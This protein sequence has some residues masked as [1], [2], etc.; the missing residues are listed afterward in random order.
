MLSPS[1]QLG[2]LALF[3]TATVVAPSLTLRQAADQAHVLV[4]TAV[5]PSL[6]SEAAYSATLTREFNMIEAE[7]VMKWGII[8]QNAGTFDFRAG[9]EV[10]RFGQ[11]HSMKV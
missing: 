11:A 10:V 7:D 2:F 6:F 8:R 9:D 3:V 1:Q 5:R 4:G